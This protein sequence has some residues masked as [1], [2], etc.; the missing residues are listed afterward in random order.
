MKLKY[1]ESLDSMQ[2]KETTLGDIGTVTVVYGSPEQVRWWL[3]YNSYTKVSEH[4]H[5]TSVNT[6]G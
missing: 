2:I 6:M 1:I 4:M 3:L 5:M